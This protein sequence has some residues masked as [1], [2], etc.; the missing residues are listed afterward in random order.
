MIF[1]M[2]NNLSQH[3]IKPEYFINVTLKY[4]DKLGVYTYVQ[5]FTALSL[6]KMLRP[7]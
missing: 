4:A 2:G 3:H 5:I 7:D 6:L 1:N